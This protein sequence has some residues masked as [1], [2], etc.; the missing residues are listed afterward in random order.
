MKKQLFFDDSLLFGRDNV[1][2]KYGEPKLCSV[3]Y[4]GVCSTDLCTGSVFKLDDGRYRMLYFGNLEGVKSRKLFSAI[5]LNGTDFVPECEVLELDFGT[6]IAFIYEDKKCADKKARYKMLLASM[7]CDKLEVRDSVRISTDLL[8][9]SAPL[10]NISWAD[11][12]EPLTSV[13]YN[14]HKDVHTIIERPFWGVRCVGYKQ[15]KDFKNFSEFRYCLGVD[16]EEEKLCEVYGM[17]AFEYD[18]MYIGIAH[19][20]RNLHSELNAKYKGGIIDTVLA[21]SY[22]GEYWRK[23]LRTPFLTGTDGRQTDGTVYNL[24]WCASVQRMDDGS[25]N[26]YSSASENEHGNFEISGTG[27]ILVFNL[28]N[29]GFVCLK[30]ENSDNASSV[31]TREKIWHGG[32]LHVNIKAKSATM[33]VYETN[34]T[35]LV[36]SNV[37]GFSAPVPG[38]THEDCIPF[39]GDCTDW[40]PTFRL[41]KTVDELSGKTLVFEIRFNDGELFSIS[42][43]YTDVFNTESARYRKFGVLPQ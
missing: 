33:A 3:Y 34:E 5:S 16:S 37:L 23:S 18:G 7:I 22:D 10:E 42:G 17:N 36:S 15:T 31:A 12:T 30:S 13:F 20:Y 29:D 21:Y 24:L 28:R 1:I 41:G 38:M 8:N 27:R 14:K 32:E 4:D 6:E 26:I 9:W 19:L 2:R 39:S 43:D 25:V 35:E 40:V 11:G